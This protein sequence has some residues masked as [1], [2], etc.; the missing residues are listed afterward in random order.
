MKKVTYNSIKDILSLDISAVTDII[1]LQEIKIQLIDAWNYLNKHEEYGLTKD[2]L[3][4]G[5]I[6][7]ISCEYATGFRPR[8]LYMARNVQTKI[9][10]INKRLQQIY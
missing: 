4:R 5:F 6:L 10:E 3:E 7:R 1:K 9:E 2:S 8:D